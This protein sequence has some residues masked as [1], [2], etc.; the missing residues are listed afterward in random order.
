HHPVPATVG[1]VFPGTEIRIIDESGKPLP[2]GHKGLVMARGPQVMKGYYKQPDL[3]ARILG[4]DGW[5]NTGDLGMLTWDNELAIRGR[6]KDTIVLRGGEN[7]EPLPIEQKLTESP[8][9]DHAIMQGQDQRVLGVLIVPN[10]EAL[11]Q[12]AK[13]AGI[14][15][16]DAEYDVSLLSNEKVREIY[17]SLIREQISSKNGFRQFE[18]IGPFKLIAGPLSIGDELSQKQEVKRHVIA[19]KYASEIEELFE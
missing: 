12:A 14:V 10:P 17:G 15:G 3:T 16:D 4:D 19:E 11:L 7:V 9:I 5:L 8:L 2:P 13:D 6:A 18:R 1:P